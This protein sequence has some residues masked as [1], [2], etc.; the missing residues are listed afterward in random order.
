MTNFSH[1]T[2]ARP[3]RRPGTA[4]P[5]AIAALSVAV[6]MLCGAPASA[7]QLK[8]PRKGM[9]YFT[10]GMSLDPGFLY[11]PGAEALRGDAGAATRTKYAFTTA[12]MV[13][14]GLTQVIN[15][16][17]FMAVE[18]GVGLQWMRPHTAA[19]DGLGPSATRLAWQLGLGGQWL[20][21]GEE[22]GWMVSAGL[23][24]YRV[25]LADAPL[26]LLGADW[27]VGKYFWTDDERF[28]LVQLGYTLPLIQ[29]L[30][31]PE[32]FDTAGWR[33]EDWSFQRFTLGF[34]YGF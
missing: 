14:M 11:D 30:S 24:L 2:P 21:L 34:V 25:Q 27:R 4:L 1:Q 3:R 19:R 15:S 31:R 12:G 29:G 10:W 26:Q 6:C 9:Q 28:L 18:G 16:Q 13:R 17:F 20:P 5:A 7:Q 33:D 23:E 8:M 22:T 32:Q